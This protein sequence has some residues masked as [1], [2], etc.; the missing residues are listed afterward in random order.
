MNNLRLQFNSIE[1]PV[2][3]V[4]DR[5]KNTEYFWNFIKSFAKPSD[6]IYYQLSR[7]ETLDKF[8]HNANQAKKL[9]GFTW[10]L[11]RTNQ[12]NFNHW[13]RDI[14]TFDPSQY[15]PW[16][17]EKDNFFIDLHASLHAAESCNFSQPIY[18][19]HIQ[20]KWFADSIPWPEPPVFV[21]EH[22]LQPG[23]IITDYPH[24]GKSPWVSLFNNDTENLLQSCR[25][26][27]ACPPG[28][29]IHLDCRV[30]EQTTRIRKQKL[31][32]WY[33]KHIDQLEPMFSM[34]QMFRYFGEYRVGKLRNT[35]QIKLLKTQTLTSVVVDTL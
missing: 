30:S 32:E 31:T 17:Q 27:D 6:R 16:S 10:D 21:L 4:F 15:P 13:H 8:L 33:L 24:V 26:P 3:I 29:V 35:D 22:E 12:E 9:F 23:D 5:N 18:K 1:Q 25:L 19:R 11:T 20:I 14:E 28:F 34:D 7:Q 2:D